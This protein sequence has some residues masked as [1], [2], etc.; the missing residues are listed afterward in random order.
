[1]ERQ[2]DLEFATEVRA[3]ENAI[4]DA[5]VSKIGQRS[6]T[7]TATAISEH[8]SELSRVWLQHAIVARE[9]ARSIEQEWNKAREHQSRIETRGSFIG[10]GV[11][12]RRAMA[13]L[14]G[15]EGLTERWTRLIEERQTVL[16]GLLFDDRPQ[17]TARVPADQS[18]Q[19]Q[20]FTRRPAPQWRDLPLSP[21]SLPAAPEP[22]EE[23]APPIGALA[24]YLLVALSCTAWA[25]R[26]LA[27]YPS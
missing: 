16:N 26:R 17:V 22:W 4:G 27:F 2:R 21:T 13:A 12:L 6:S 3:G 15:T 9:A 7:E 8:A 11:P 20:P 23:A 24:L 18:R 10:P 25:A 14:A 19:L 5:I 1:M